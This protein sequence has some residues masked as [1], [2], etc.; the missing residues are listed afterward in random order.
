MARKARW[1]VVERVR[2]PDGKVVTHTGTLSVRSLDGIWYIGEGKGEMG[3]TIMTLGFDPEKNRYVGTFIGSM[4]TD[5]WV[6]DGQVD[7]A[8]KVLTLDTEGPSF[9]DDGSRAPYKDSIEFK[10]D[11][12]WVLSSKMKDKDGNWNGFMTANYKRIK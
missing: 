3:P 5:M 11:D 8:G 7:G 2:G 6:Y 12:H 4:M 10:N 9:A 1:R